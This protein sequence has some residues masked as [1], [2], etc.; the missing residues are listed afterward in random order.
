M[1]WTDNGKIMP[2]WI[3]LSE[4]GET[5]SEGGERKTGEGGMQVQRAVEKLFF[6]EF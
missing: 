2:P 3:T 6:K 4:Q 5:E 1:G